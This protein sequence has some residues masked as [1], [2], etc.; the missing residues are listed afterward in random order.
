M[1]AKTE[2]KYSD[3]LAKIDEYF[4]STSEIDYR[5]VDLEEIYKKVDD[6]LNELGVK[7]ENNEYDK[8]QKDIKYYYDGIYG[9]KTFKVRYAGEDLNQ[10]EVNHSDFDQNNWHIKFQVE[11]VKSKLLSFLVNY[12]E[13]ELDIYGSSEEYDNFVTKENINAYLNDLLHFSIEKDDDFDRDTEIF[14]NIANAIVKRFGDGNIKDMELRKMVATSYGDATDKSYVIKKKDGIANLIERMFRKNIKSTG[15]FK[16]IGGDKAIFDY[17]GS[18]HFE[19]EDFQSYI[20]RLVSHITK[21]LLEDKTEQVENL[22]YQAEIDKIMETNREEKERKKKERI[23]KATATAKSMPSDIF[24]T[25]ESNSDKNKPIFEPKVNPVVNEPTLNTEEAGIEYK[26]KPQ[27]TLFNE[28]TYKER[29]KIT[30]KNVEMARKIVELKKKLYDNDEIV[31]NL[32]TNSTLPVSGDNDLQEELND[33]DL[34]DAIININEQINELTNENIAI[35]NEIED[36]KTML[37]NNCTRLVE[38]LEGH[39]RK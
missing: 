21:I 24:P 28:A 25:R 1:S 2:V 29:I 35:L 31:D 36:L 17:T 20:D 9:A 30:E 22:E 14:N 6:L 11:I 19:Q 7:Y 16:N 3:I 10:E 32:L 27:A 33:N 26:T 34:L 23:E 15:N 39:G 12:E 8:L 38:T 37:N 13:R 4:P 18:E 5:E